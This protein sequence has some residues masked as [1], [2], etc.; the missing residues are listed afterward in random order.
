MTC[1]S[2]LTAAWWRRTAGES[3]FQLLWLLPRTRLVAARDLAP[4]D[5]HATGID[6][7]GREL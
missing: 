5:G 3:R 6:T 4:P 7:A 2:A 1:E